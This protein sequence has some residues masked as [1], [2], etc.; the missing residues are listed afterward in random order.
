MG[1]DLVEV[2]MTWEEVFDFGEIPESDAVILKTPA[3]VIDYIYTRVRKDNLPVDTGS[4]TLRAF[5]RLRAAFRHEM[6]PGFKFEPRSKLSAILS[7]KEKRSLLNTILESAGFAPLPK[8][9]F[10]LQFISGRMV[11]LIAQVVVKNHKT[12]RKPGYTW[13][14]E[15]VRE[16]V[17][18]VIIAKTRLRNFSDNASFRKDLNLA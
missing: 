16:V 3:E 12:L 10:G 5:Y 7:S 18:I 15:Q 8:L 13:S 9:P 1:L 11:D 14:K 2:I 4:L 6:P 17:R